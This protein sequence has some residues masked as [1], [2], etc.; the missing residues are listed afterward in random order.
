[1]RGARLLPLLASIASLGCAGPTASLPRDVPDPELVDVHAEDGFR[2]Y[3]DRACL[4]D[5]ELD[6]LHAELSEAREF[7][8]G[9]LGPGMA[10]GDFRP[11]GV[12]RQTCPPDW[13]FGPLPELGPVD[14][15]V[16]SQGGRCHA[17][18]DGLTVVRRHVARGD[19]THELVHY[20]AGSSWHP[21]DEGLA[22]WLTERIVGPDKAYPLMSRA[23]VY[24]DLNL[25]TF[26]T[27]RELGEQMSRRDYDVAG[28]FV[29]WLIQA[30][31]KARFLQLYAG[32]ARDF[33]T[34]YGTG[35]RELV[36]RFWAHVGSLDVK[37]DGGYY[38][39]K[40]L[41]QGRE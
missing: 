9:W 38:G 23:R 36:E 24:R 13:E 11:R 12:P 20:L 29:G 4:T 35:E 17:D 25:L 6:G 32:P 39:F 31:G 10:P 15:V 37:H 33:M 28:A 19:A 26:L 34:V 27:P 8:V 40:A 16:L 5:D 1:V 14:V 2:Y 7:L 41:L 21:I 30:F 3:V 22:T 18:R